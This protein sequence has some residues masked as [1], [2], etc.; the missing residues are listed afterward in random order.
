MR[1]FARYKL[2]RAGLLSIA[3][4]LGMFY[5]SLFPKVVKRIASQKQILGWEAITGQVKVTKQEKRNVTRAPPRTKIPEKFL[6]DE[7]DFCTKQHPNLDV[8]AYVHSSISKDDLRNATRT[9]WANATAQGL[10]LKLA[11]V[12]VVGRPETEK[13]AMIVREESQR[14]HD[15]IQ[16]DYKDEYRL[17]AYKALASLSW[18]TQ[19]CQQVPWTL[20]SDDDILIDVFGLA[21]VLQSV[22]ANSTEKF[23]CHS[24]TGPVLRKGKWSVDEAEYPASKYPTY[25]A[26]GM[27][28]LQTKQIP[29]LLEASKVAPFIWVDDVYVCGILRTYA[30]IKQ[31]YL[32]DKYTFEFNI[33]HLG[34]KFAWLYAGAQRQMGW[35]AILDY[36]R[37][38]SDQFLLL[39]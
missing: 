25:C 23:L 20:H 31:L 12:F 14:Y 36:H 6:I 24:G 7:I 22:D 8:I 21:K 2:Q 18:I 35:Q 4:V 17:L 30:G 3:F 28:I 33:T 11:A 9:T 5:Q 10:A 38:I 1:G 26:G 19:H 13:E 29:R 39:Q 16:I 37:N 27:W 15:I 34:K 32:N